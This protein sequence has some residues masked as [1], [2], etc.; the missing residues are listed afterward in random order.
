M[1]SKAAFGHVG[2]AGPSMWVDP[3][4]DLFVIVLTNWVAGSARGGVA[5]IAVLHDVRS[6]IADLAALAVMDGEAREM[7]GHLRSDARIG[8]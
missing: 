2:F 4:R 3:D 8:W 5:P 6:D 7:P 1:A